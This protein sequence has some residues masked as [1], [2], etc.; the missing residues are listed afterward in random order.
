M[1]GFWVLTAMTIA[2]SWLI[3]LGVFMN[4]GKR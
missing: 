3:S 1:A 4:V 2:I